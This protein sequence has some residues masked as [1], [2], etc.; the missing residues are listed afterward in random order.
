[1]KPKFSCRGRVE[2]F[3]GLVLGA[4]I[5]FSLAF[6]DA[7]TNLSRSFI[8]GRIV[9]DD[10]L[11]LPLSTS[12]TLKCGT[13]VLQA[14]HPD[15]A[16]NFQFNFGAGAIAADIDMSAAN[17]I[18][19]PQENGH[20]RSQD[21]D[22]Y[23]G[24]A[25]LSC[26]LDVSAPEYRPLSKSIMLSDSADVGGLD[27]GPLILTPIA[28]IRAGMISVTSLLVPKNARK[29]FEKGDQE[30]QGN[31]L[32]SAI[33]Y[34]KK[35]VTEYDK[36]AAA[37]NALGR[38]YSATHESKQASNAF[39]KATMADPKYIPPYVGLAALELHDGEYENA[40]ATAEEALTLDPNVALAVFI[41]AAAN[42]K[43]N[44]LDAAEKSA[45]EAERRPHQNIP[46]LHALLA[47]IYLRKQDDLSAAPEMRAYLKEWPQGEV[48]GK[49][50][51]ELEEIE[52]SQ[53]VINKVSALPVEIAP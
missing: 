26:E 30:A 29:D 43:M 35:A 5:L 6:A 25:F 38:V 46:Q 10:D 13:Q 20:I 32:T 7:Q 12:V 14:I 36:Y 33:E 22:R 40:L 45:R 49:M 52:K 37:W 44:R 48:A 2:I 51:V 19:L 15:P 9:G 47:E 31:H 8:Y 16:G 24:I 34:L 21:S 4:A 1:M 18:S 11:G 27:V 53:P 23:M 42:Y 28:P 17:G 39:E 50:K 3:A 41:Q